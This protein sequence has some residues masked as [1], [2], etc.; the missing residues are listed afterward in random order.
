MPISIWGVLADAP[1]E[2]KRLCIICGRRSA[3]KSSF[4]EAWETLALSLEEENHL[5]EA[6]ACWERVHQLD[7]AG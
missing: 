6:L 1:V 4:K 2:R 3:L 5:P 7:P